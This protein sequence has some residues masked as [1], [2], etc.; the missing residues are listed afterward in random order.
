MFVLMQIVSPFFLSQ[1]ERQCT[2][3]GLTAHPEELNISGDQTKPAR[4]G[5]DGITPPLKVAPYPTNTKT[6]N[7]RGGLDAGMGVPHLLS[8]I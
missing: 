4:Q 8:S 2:A 1:K 3:D 5:N 6:Q 7:Q